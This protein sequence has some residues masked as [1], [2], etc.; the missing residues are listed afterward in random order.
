MIEVSKLHKM[1]KLESETAAAFA[2]M[3]AKEQQAYIKAHPSSK[4]AHGNAANP[5]SKGPNQLHMTSYEGGHTD[6]ANHFKKLGFSTSVK[7]LRGD[8]AG[9]GGHQVTVH[10][11]NQDASNLLKHFKKHDHGQ[12]YDNS[13]DFPGTKDYKS[14]KALHNNAKA[15]KIKA[16]VEDAILSKRWPKP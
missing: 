2:D 8:D 12:T 4:Y 5:A 11:H 13:A 1:L 10:Y 7:K 14:L 15:A 3:T 16:P 6:T 9:D